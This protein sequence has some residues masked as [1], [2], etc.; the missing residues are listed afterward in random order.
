MKST[1]INPTA[2]YSN[3]DDRL[4]APGTYTG[5]EILT[6]IVMFGDECDGSEDWDIEEGGAA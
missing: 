6:Q 4:G 1:E 2:S 5:A 3:L